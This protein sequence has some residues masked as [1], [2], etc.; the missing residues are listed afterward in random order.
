ML[1]DCAMICPASVADQSCVFVMGVIELEVYSYRVR[2]RLS[3]SELVASDVSD[4][5]D[6]VRY[7]EDD[8]LP[9]GV[10][11]GRKTFALRPELYCE[12]E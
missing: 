9:V 7:I 11:G 12:V 8:A 4:I 2:F 10:A 6:F 1:A 3:I 5:V